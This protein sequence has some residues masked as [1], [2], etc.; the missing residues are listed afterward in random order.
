MDETVL[1]V[2]YNKR[3]DKEGRVCCDRFEVGQIYHIRGED[4]NCIS[5]ERK[6]YSQLHFRINFDSGVYIDMF[7]FDDVICI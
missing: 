2:I 4:T 1:E 3:Y 6:L 7:N 5:I